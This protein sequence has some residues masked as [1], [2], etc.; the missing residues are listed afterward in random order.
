MHRRFSRDLLPV[1]NLRRARLSLSPKVLI[2]QLW[3]HRSQFWLYTATYVPFPLSHHPSP[4]PNSFPELLTNLKSSHPIAAPNLR[5]S[6][7]SLALTLLSYA[8]A[9]STGK[10]YSQL[11]HE[12]ILTPLNM[13]NTGISPG[14]DSLGVISSTDNSWGSY[15]GDNAPFVPLP[16]FLRNPT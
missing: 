6:Y 16:F 4:R 5:P 7:S 8:L 1:L 9:S 2:P 12:Q 15:Y 14:N 3:R 11:L 13:T 10:S